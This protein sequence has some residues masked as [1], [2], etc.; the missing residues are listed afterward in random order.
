MI[1]L[2]LSLYAHYPLFTIHH[3]SFIIHYSL[4]TPSTPYLL[5]FS[6]L[7]SLFTIHYSLLLTSCYS[8]FII[9][10][11]LSIILYPLPRIHLRRGKRQFREIALI[12]DSR[13]VN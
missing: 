6:I 10:H 9:H 13:G 11:S 4:F 1:I 3:S 5:L 7:Y 12:M 8:P 2:S